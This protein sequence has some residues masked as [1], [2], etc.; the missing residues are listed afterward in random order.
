MVLFLPLVGGRR[1]SPMIKTPL[2]FFHLSVPIS[3]P[4]SNLSF[5]TPCRAPGRMS[6]RLG[7]ALLSPATTSP[8]PPTSP[9]RFKL[10]RNSDLESWTESKIIDLDPNASRTSPMTPE[11]F[12]AKLASLSPSPPPSPAYTPSLSAYVITILHNTHNFISFYFYI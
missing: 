2:F 1:L 9:Q 10:E 11:E 12:K 7:S 5:F 8:P 4:T 6:G 3:F